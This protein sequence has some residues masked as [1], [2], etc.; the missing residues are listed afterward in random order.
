VELLQVHRSLRLH[1]SLLTK[2]CQLQLNL[3][4]R[5]TR[6]VCIHWLHHFSVG[7]S[8]YF[9][10]VQY[11]DFSGIIPFL[12][13]T[14]GYGRWGLSTCTCISTEEG[15]E[16]C[17]SILTVFQRYTDQNLLFVCRGYGQKLGSVHSPLW[18]VLG[19]ESN[20]VTSKAYQELQTLFRTGKIQKKG[21]VVTICHHT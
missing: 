13:G 20:L 15:V 21:F 6:V 17:R 3:L 19:L 18:T 9:D 2:K 16:L 7:P 5:Q 10:R 11:K 12:Y 14:D 1:A 8:Y 4:L